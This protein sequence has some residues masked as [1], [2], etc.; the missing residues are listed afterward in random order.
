MEGVQALALHVLNQPAV[1]TFLEA[2]AA[3]ESYFTPLVKPLG[4]V[5]EDVAKQYLGSALVEDVQSTIA[6]LA[7]PYA[8]RLPLMNPFHVALIAAAYLS[9]VFAGVFVMSFFSRFN[10]KTLAMVHNVFM[11]SLSGYMMVGILVEAIKSNYVVWGNPVDETNG[12]PVGM[13]KMVWLFYVSKIFE[14]T[15]TVIMILKKNNRQISFLHVY[16]HSSIFVIWWVVCYVAPGGESYFSAILNSFIHVVMYGYYFLSSMG[17]SAVSF[18]KKYI[19]LMQMTQFCCMMAQATFLLVHPNPFPKGATPYP[20][21]I[22]TLLFWYMWTMLGLFG[23][24]F[25]RDRQ[26]AAALRKKQK[27]E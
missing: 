19:T 4:D 26:R 8:A 22:A 25:I 24:F 23:N 13:A 5:V 15:D 9:V 12:W 6:S 18:V 11:V 2:F 3:A 14:F 16:H 17:V 21:H 7:S 1:D 27:A 10:A 20:R